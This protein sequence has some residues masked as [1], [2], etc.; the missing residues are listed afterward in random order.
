MIVVLKPSATGEG[1]F[2]TLKDIA[3][4]PNDPHGVKAIAA[5]VFLGLSPQEG[6]VRRVHQDE[7]LK[8]RAERPKIQAFQEWL[9]VEAHGEAARAV[10]AP[11]L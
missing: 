5:S 3:H 4:F 6:E 2:L 9:M 10:G 7:I 1:P 8:L 11:V